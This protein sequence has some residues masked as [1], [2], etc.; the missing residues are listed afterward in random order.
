MCTKSSCA[1][2]F[3][4]ANQK[5][6]A[7][8]QSSCLADSIMNA[9]RLMVLC[10]LFLST[11]AFACRCKEP[12]IEQTFKSSSM[13]VYATVKDFIPSPLDEGGTAIILIDTWWKSSSPEKI[14][15]NSLTN[16]R[17][18]F[19]INKSYLL[20]LKQESS[21]LFYTDKCSGNKDL[22]SKDEFNGIFT[23]LKYLSSRAI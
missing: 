2:E 1:K 16:C 8:N 13:V 6:Q 4:Q 20:F 12:S 11:S 14:V 18:N 10:F 22:T 7:Q 21:G 5:L 23:N 19:E 15:V 3:H 17:F 9:A